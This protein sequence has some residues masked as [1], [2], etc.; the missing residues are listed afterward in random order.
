MLN[1]KSALLSLVSAVMVLPTVAKADLVVNGGFETG[2]LTGWSC[3]A[4]SGTCEA[5]TPTFG[6][7]SGSFSF[8][9]FN[10]SSIFGTLFQSI[11]TTVGDSYSLS[12]WAATNNISSVNQF[13]YEIDGGPVTAITPALL[14]YDQ[15]TASFV[16][17]S[18]AT[19]IEFFYETQSGSGALYLDD[20]SV[21]DTTAAV[22]GPVVGAGL[23]GL[24]L[25]SG[26]L[27]AWR[28]RRRKTASVSLRTAVGEA[29]EPGSW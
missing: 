10:N 26:G 22:P 27:L 13:E 21:V 12:F 6:T 29:G 3:S 20:V 5:I 11:A 23:P 17:I 2:D 18:S 15:I 14:S 8:Y 16:A 9:G 19:T 4:P 1:H 7:H 24:I 25:V 28:L